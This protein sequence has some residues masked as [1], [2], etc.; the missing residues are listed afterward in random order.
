MYTSNQVEGERKHE[1]HLGG[2]SIVDSCN[3][4]AAPRGPVPLL[5]TIPPPP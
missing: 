5:T 4:D 3:V 2:A 1:E